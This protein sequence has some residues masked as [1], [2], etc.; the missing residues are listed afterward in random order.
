MN[1][2]LNMFIILTNNVYVHVSHTWYNGKPAHIMFTLFDGKMYIYMYHYYYMY[3][4][5]SWK[6]PLWY[7]IFIIKVVQ[8]LFYGSGM[9]GFS[10]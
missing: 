6:M 10:I 2:M 8:T 3:I 5:I 9:K 7:H 4:I 1:Y